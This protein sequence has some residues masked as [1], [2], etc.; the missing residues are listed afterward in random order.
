MIWKMNRDIL[1]VI[2]Y[3]SNTVVFA[4]LHARWYLMI[5]A[6]DMILITHFRCEYGECIVYADGYLSVVLLI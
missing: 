5:P 2:L 3:I 1:L 6:I 4:S